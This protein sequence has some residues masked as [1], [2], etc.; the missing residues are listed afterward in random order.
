MIVFDCTRTV[1]TP[2]S[3]NLNVGSARPEMRSKQTC[4]AANSATTTSAMP[5]AWAGQRI[6]PS[7][8]TAISAIRGG[9]GTMRILG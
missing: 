9:L 1:K 2:K 7:V 4:L 6:Y 8:L 3:P 5:V